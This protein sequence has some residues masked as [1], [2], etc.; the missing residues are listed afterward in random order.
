MKLKKMMEALLKKLHEEIHMGS[1]AMI[2]GVKEIRCRAKN[3][4][5]CRYNSKEMKLV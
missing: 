2:S 3:A 4:D 1:N 5:K